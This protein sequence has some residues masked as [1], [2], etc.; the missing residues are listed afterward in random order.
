MPTTGGTLSP[1]QRFTP[2]PLRSSGFDALAAAL[3]K[4]CNDEVEYRDLSLGAPGRKQARP[5]IPM[6]FMQTGSVERSLEKLLKA[7]DGFVTRNIVNLIYTLET[8][9]LNIT[10]QS[11]RASV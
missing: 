7:L 6:S 1:Q 10:S 11:S 2:S 9:S 8:A 5:N 3:A 4:R